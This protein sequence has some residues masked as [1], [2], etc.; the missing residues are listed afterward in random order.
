MSRGGRL[1]KASAVMLLIVVTASPLRAPRFA[2]G[3]SYFRDALAPPSPFETP[4]SRAPHGEGS[5][6]RLAGSPLSPHPEE[7]PP[8][9][10]SKDEETCPPSFFPAPLFPGGEI[11]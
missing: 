7:L 1:T 2:D 6:R 3:L 9:G 4:A 11:V 8:A 5:V 10:V